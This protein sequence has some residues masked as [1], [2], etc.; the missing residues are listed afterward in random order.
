VAE[1]PLC[2]LRAT[3]LSPNDQRK[4]NFAG[5]NQNDFAGSGKYSAS[6]YLAVYSA[7]AITPQAM[8]AGAL[9]A[10]VSVTA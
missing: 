10:E 4:G 7:F 5:G 3:N 6:I 1:N 2:R 8:R 9:A